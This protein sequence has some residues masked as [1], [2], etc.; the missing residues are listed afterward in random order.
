MLQHSRPTIDGEDIEAVMRVLRSGHIAQG[1]LVEEFEDSFKKL[2]GVES[3]VATN[4]GSSALHLSLLA[5][6]VGKGDQVILPSYACAAVLN[7]VSYV[8]AE[9]RLCDIS[10]EDLNLR[11]SDVKKEVNKRT[12][13]IV[14]VHT[15]GQPADVEGFLELGIPIIEDCAQSLGARSSG[16]SVGSFG[17]LSIFSFYA[18]KMITAGYGG[19]V[20]SNSRDLAEKVRDLREFDERQEYKVRYNYKMSD[21]EASLGLSQIGKLDAFITKRKEIAQLYDETFSRY[22]MEPAYRKKLSDHIFYRY[23]IKVRNRL[24]DVIARLAL[25][26]IEAKRPVY[27]PLHYYLGLRES[28][29]PN[30]EEAYN[31]VLSIPIYPSLDRDKAEYVART[32]GEIVL[33]NDLS[34]TSA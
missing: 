21:I 22:G 25:T 10:E 17:T 5:L 32:T 19:M 28:G 14:L 34:R 23:V 26:G 27:K 9:A 11:A 33:E 4:S 7:A 18:T 16:K 30:A 20:T 15:F 29:F 1:P 31:S 3:A 2:L 12:K 6:G 8:R 13:A 24:D